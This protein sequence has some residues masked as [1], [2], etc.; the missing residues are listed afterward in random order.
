MKMMNAVFLTFSATF[1]SYAF[2]TVGGPETIQF[3]GYE[4][5]EQK[6]YLLRH[7]Q[8]ESGRLPQL[9]YYQF[10]KTKTYQKLIE[11]KSIY[12]NPKTKKVD[13]EQDEQTFNKRLKVIQNRLEPLITGNTITAK[14][15]ILNTQTKQI[16]HGQDPKFKITQYKYQYRVAN[17]V[18]SSQTQTAYA[19]KASLKI[20][21]G[22]IVPHQNKMVVAV[23]YLGLPNEVGYTKEDPVV[24]MPK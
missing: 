16:P 14:I 4:T 9:Y 23:Q 17:K 15:E 7:Y 11:V 18:Q 24:L 1:T 3:L 22:F 12:I 8:D 20:S 13:L 5:K 19:Y 10:D 6:L 2:A 21:Q